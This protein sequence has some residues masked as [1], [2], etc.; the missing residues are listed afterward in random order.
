M[1]GKTIQDGGYV[2]ESTIKAGGMQKDD[3]LMAV[4]QEAD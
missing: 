3:R 2:Q 4:S 1:Q